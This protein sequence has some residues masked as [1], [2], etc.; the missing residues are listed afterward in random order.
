MY[1]GITIFESG[2]LWL[3]NRLMVAGHPGLDGHCTLNLYQNDITLP[4]YR[5]LADFKDLV[6]AGYSPWTLTGAVDAGIDMNLNDT[7]YWPTTD[8]VA[9]SAPSSPVTAF[10][11]YVTAD[12]DGTLLWGG[13]FP[14]PAI[15]TLLG[16]FVSFTPPLSFGNL[17]QLVPPGSAPVVTGISPSSGSTAGGTS[18]TITG[19]Y[20]AGLLSVDFGG[21]AASSVTLVSYDVITCL[22][23]AQPAGTVDVRVT[24]PNGNSAVVPADQFDYS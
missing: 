16:D 20:F 10:G 17:M 3:M 21:Y 23:P 22:S 11:Y 6:L 9:T 7:W 19:Q 18:V 4:P 13:S 2:R 24:T 12:D 15:W 14:V 1:P 5:V 8:V